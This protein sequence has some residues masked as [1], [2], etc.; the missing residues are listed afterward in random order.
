MGAVLGAG[1]ARCMW[2][3]G[4][5]RRDERAHFNRTDSLTVRQAGE[6]GRQAGR[7]ADIQTDGQADRQAGRQADRQTCTDA[8]PGACNCA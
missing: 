3:C 2:R 7:Q 1:D 6:A 5:G 8:P 4:L